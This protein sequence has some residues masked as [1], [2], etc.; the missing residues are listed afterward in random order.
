M[1]WWP[2]TRGAIACE[3]LPPTPGD[4]ATMTREQ[5]IDTFF[6]YWEDKRREFYEIECY[7][8]LD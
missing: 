6:E 3:V 4:P 8:V 1:E 7:E 2:S 5:R